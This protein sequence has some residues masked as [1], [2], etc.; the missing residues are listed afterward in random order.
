MEIQEKKCKKCLRPLP[1][2]GMGKI[3]AKDGICP[4]CLRE[5]KF[6]VF[7]DWN[8]KKGEFESIIA[9]LKGKHNFDGLVM[10]NRGELIYLFAD[11]MEVN[12]YE[13]FVYPLQYFEYKPIEIAELLK[14]EVGWEAD[15]HFTGKYISSGCKMAKIM[16]YVAYKNQTDTYVDREFSDQIRRGSLTV[17]EVNEIMASRIVQD[18]EREEIMKQLGVEE[19]ELF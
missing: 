18:G 5:S 9:Q 4:D 1:V 2:N 16:E 12:E 7:V 8:K 17:E 10:L 19:A 3:L 11:N 15:G 13:N 6:H 14:R